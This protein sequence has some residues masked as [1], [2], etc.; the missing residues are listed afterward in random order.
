M[1]SR[2]TSYP[3]GAFGC[4]PFTYINSLSQELLNQ[5]FYWPDTLPVTQPTASKHRRKRQT[6]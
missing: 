6:K 1:T 4:I 3:Y 5:T 2:K